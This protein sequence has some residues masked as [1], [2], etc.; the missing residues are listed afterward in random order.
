MSSPSVR[1]SAR[2]RKP[3][4]KYSTDVLDNEV[5][6]L[7]RESSESSHHI[8]PDTSDSEEVTSDNNLDILIS[9][10]QANV[11][12]SVVHDR[13]NISVITESTRGA[14]N[15]AESLT[16]RRSNDTLNID[17]PVL[18]VSSPLPESEDGIRQQ[19]STLFGPSDQDILPI[20]HVRDRWLGSEDATFPSRKTLAKSI[21]E[22]VYGKTVTG[23]ISPE[24]LKEEATRGWDWL[25]GDQGAIFQER[26]RVEEVSKETAQARYLPELSGEGHEVVM[27]PWNKQE[28][29]R[30]EDMCALDFGQAW[31]IQNS[32][33]VQT[34]S[35]A[36]DPNELGIA[37]STDVA[38]TRATT[39]SSTAT[40][41][42]KERYHEGFLLNLG[43]KVQCLAWAPTDANS[44]IQ[45]LA[46][47]CSNASTQ[48]FSD[49]P[50]P[51]ILTSNPSPSPPI[52]SSIQIWAFRSASQAP[53]TLTKLDITTKPKLVQVL[54]TDWGDVRQ[55]IWCCTSSQSHASTARHKPSPGKEWLG[56]LGII[57]SDGSARVLDIRVCLPALDRE[58]QYLRMSSPAFAMSPPSPA[59]CIGLAFASTSDLIIATSTGALG[60]YDIANPLEPNSP[61][62]HMSHQLESTHLAG[63][64]S[65][66]LSPH[67]TILA[68]ASASGTLSL[69]E[70]RCSSPENVCTSKT[71]NPPL[72]LTYSPLAQTFITTS[73]GHS[74]S[75]LNVKSPSML[76]C[77]S[78]RHFMGGTNITLVP[79]EGPVTALAASRW[80]PSILLGTAD[81]I[82]LSTNYLRKFI[83]QAQ[84]TDSSG[85][86]IQKLCEYQWIPTKPAAN[87]SPREFLPQPPEQ[88]D[89]EPSSS[90]AHTARPSHRDRGSNVTEDQR[91]EA[92]FP[93][94]RN[95]RPGRSRFHEGFQAERANVGP[96]TPRNKG[97][98]FGI[99]TIFQEEQGVTAVDWNP[100]LSCAGWLAVAWGSGLVRVQD[101]AHG[102]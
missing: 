33:A 94:V 75:P 36:A 50:L 96:A 35:P 6:R 9:A 28:I 59:I 53:Q 65:A 92:T 91:I 45:Y 81:G 93:F 25:Q 76:A 46:V 2:Q 102:T 8:S 74:N 70:L 71:S 5:L 18:D 17:T 37:I 12:S 61:E 10:V 58:T 86:F 4:T 85:A 30:I 52:P 29:F 57:T 82:V 84:V 20:L 97:E 66:H 43:K 24:R 44:S 7:L 11:T 32:V 40:S 101:V 98:D 60:I 16:P 39:T 64:S 13:N 77:H 15:G 42:T 23:G 26:Q 73:G 99:T 48:S 19:L 63:I 69:I 56:L 67:P 80:H 3:N 41:C 54:C 1:R 47:S 95:N 87:L 55:L 22:G 79:A 78:V 34:V 100:N 38:D 72:H 27:G 89:D 90:I 21:A 14:S 62:P 68:S 49:V 83:P 51:A 88:F 31:E